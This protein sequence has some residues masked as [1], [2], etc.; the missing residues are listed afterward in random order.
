MLCWRFPRCHIPRICESRD[1]N[2]QT[3][4]VRLIR[5]LAHR[6]CFREEC[7]E[8]AAVVEAEEREVSAVW[9]D[10]VWTDFFT[11][12]WWRDFLSSKIALAS[13]IPKLAILVSNS[14]DLLMPGNLSRTPRT[15]HKKSESSPRVFRDWT[16]QFK[17]CQNL[18]ISLAS[19]QISQATH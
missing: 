14:R 5:E 1:R 4:V 3:R 6:N 2:K 8:D 18:W 16:L 19:S 7:E 17:V 10:H 11:S 12:I 13:R 9:R 15:I